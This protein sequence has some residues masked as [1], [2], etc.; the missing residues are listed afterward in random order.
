MRSRMSGVSFC[1]EFTFVEI[2]HIVSSSEK[3]GFSR[4]CGSGLQVAQPARVVF[5]MQDHRH[6]VGVSS[7]CLQLL[8][9]RLG[10]AGAIKVLGYVLGDPSDHEIDSARP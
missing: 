7:V 4:S 1:G 9:Q 3:N 6:A 2:G 10:I 8:G 5:G